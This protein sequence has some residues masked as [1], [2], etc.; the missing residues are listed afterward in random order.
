M[1]LAIHQHSDITQALAA[2]DA[3]KA[4][5]LTRTHIRNGFER[6]VQPLKQ[7]AAARTQET[8]K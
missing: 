6:R 2:R 5:E 1:T 4:G 8:L 7:S 3:R